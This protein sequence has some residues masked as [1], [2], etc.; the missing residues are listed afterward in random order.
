MFLIYKINMA[1]V[2]C[3]NL[4][5]LQYPTCT[6]KRAEKALSCSPF[7]INLFVTMGV[8]SVRLKSKISE[9]SLKIPT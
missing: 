8:Q 6:V 2:E 5:S 7:Q 3:P 9:I 1:S 4:I